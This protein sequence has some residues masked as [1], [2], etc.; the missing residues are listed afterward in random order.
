MS[1]PTLPPLLPNPGP[2]CSLLWQK[3]GSFASNPGET[4]T[5]T[6]RGLKLAAV[7]LALDSALQHKEED[8]VP[9]PAP[10]L[11][12]DAGRESCFPSFEAAWVFVFPIAMSSG[13]R[14]LLELKAEQGQ[15]GAARG[16][17]LPRRRQRQ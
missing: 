8:C 14:G 15:A 12:L 16:R 17:R 2:S 10:W 7:V 6:R 4:P 5:S 1:L 3:T 13:A 11:G 9:L